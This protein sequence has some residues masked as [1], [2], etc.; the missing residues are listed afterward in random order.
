MCKYSES[1]IAFKSVKN[2]LDLMLGK[3]RKQK[4]ND[5]SQCH[6]HAYQNT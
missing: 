1:H 5:L 6:C 2:K 3:I 4:N